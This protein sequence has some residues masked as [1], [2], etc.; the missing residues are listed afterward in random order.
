M[1]S[2]ALGVVTGLLILQA[3][4]TAPRMA[5]VDCLKQT[6]AKAKSANVPAAQYAAFVKSNCAPQVEAYR[7][8]MISF[9]VKNGIKRPKATE[10]A[11]FQIDDFISISAEKYALKGGS[12]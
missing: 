8:A 7:S 2:L 5:F 4:V 3:G 12:Q 6:S 10:D 1:I 11:D 9:D